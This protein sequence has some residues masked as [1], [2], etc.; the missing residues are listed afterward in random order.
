MA[1]PKSPFGAPEEPIDPIVMSAPKKKEK[2]ER[3]EETFSQDLINAQR[4][5]VERD[6]TDKEVTARLKTMKKDYEEMKK[7]FG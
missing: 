4:K 3:K 6:E 2:K 1:R 7:I 5:R